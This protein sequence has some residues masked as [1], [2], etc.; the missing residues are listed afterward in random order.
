MAAA[1]ANLLTTSREV[2]SIVLAMAVAPSRSGFDD[3]SFLLA[4]L[5]AGDE[6]GLEESY[7]AFGDIV[8]GIAR[9]ITGDVRAAEDVVQEVFVQLW[10]RADQVDLDKCSLRGWLSV[11]AHRR[12]V[13]SVRGEQRVRR[14]EERVGNELAVDAGCTTID[15]ADW[16]VVAD[17]ADRARAAVASLPPDLRRAI[18]LAYWQGHS[19]REVG[20]ELGIPEGTAKSRLRL[21]LARLAVLLEGELV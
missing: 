11:L 12:A 20:E 6:A 14:R 2:S 17:R 15:L 16:A 9:R 5:V 10:Q 19:Y 18:E 4:R 3:D 8:F 21:G 7:D 1:T 13:D